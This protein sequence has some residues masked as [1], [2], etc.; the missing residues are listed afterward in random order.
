MFNRL[1]TAVLLASLAGLMLFIGYLLGG[2]QGL[3]IGLIIALI[4]N[5]GSYW[6]SDRI[7]LAMYKAKEVKDQGHHLYKIVKDVSHLANIPMPKV[8]IIPSAQSN[9]FACGRDYNHSAVA[10]TEG[11]LNL[12]NQDELKGVIAHEV[13]HIKNRDILIQ[14][15]AATIAAVI[16]YVA[17]MARWAAIF[18]GFGGRDKNNS[19]ILEFLAL[20]ILAPILALIIQLAISRSREY[21]A[22]A[23][24]AK[25]LHSPFGLANAL[26]K[27]DVDGKKNRMRL[28]NPSTAHM[29]IS[30]PFR[31]NFLMSILSTH[32]PAKSRIKKLRDMNI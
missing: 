29:F 18:G 2:Y 30:N 7:V 15:I 23:S 4:F 32:P 10:A 11:L 8:Y 28:G 31:G 5:F 20:A 3:T 6:F 13:S 22:D 19:G 17:M 25:L 1:K 9:A 26:E 27:L 16:S 21:L 24:A 12:M 14:T